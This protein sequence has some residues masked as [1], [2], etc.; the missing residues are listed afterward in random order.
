M[1]LLFLFTVLV[2]AR[3]QPFNETIK[4][5]DD[6]KPLKIKSDPPPIKW[7]IKDNLIEIIY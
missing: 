1:F 3:K 6:A 2:F 4:F 7:N 5:V